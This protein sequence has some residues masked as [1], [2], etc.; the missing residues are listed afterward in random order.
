[1]LLKPVNSNA[2]HLNTTT[3]CMLLPR[4]KWCYISGQYMKQKIINNERTNWLNT[5][6]SGKIKI[7]ITFTYL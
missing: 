5:Q 7:S 1:M 4:N 2:I 6:P 3:P